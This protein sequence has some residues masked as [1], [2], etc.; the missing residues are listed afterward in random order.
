MEWSF[1]QDRML[2]TMETLLNP[3]RTKRY[4]CCCFTRKI[5]VNK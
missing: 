2:S 3:K 4:F 1:G 5:N